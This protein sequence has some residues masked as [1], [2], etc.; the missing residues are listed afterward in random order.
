M[1]LFG[2][3]TRGQGV[4][5]IHLV[6]EEGQQLP[7]AAISVETLDGICLPFR[8]DE[9][10]KPGHFMLTVPSLQTPI[11]V[12]INDGTTEGVDSL[13]IEPKKARFESRKNRLLGNR[14]ARNMRKLSER[15]YGA[16]RSIV[17]SSLIR[18]ETEEKLV[19]RGYIVEMAA[20]PSTASFSLHVLDGQGCEVAL[21]E[22]M[23]LSDSIT[24]SKTC[25]AL[26]ERAVAF[27][28]SV[29]PRLGTCLI[30]AVSDDHPSDF[31]YCYEPVTFRD[32]QAHFVETVCP[33]DQDPRYEQWFYEHRTTRDELAAQRQAHF[34]HEAVFS[35]I[36]PLFNT[37][38][39]FFREMVDSVLAQTY[40]YFELILVNASPERSD[41]AAE[42]TRYAQCDSRIKVVNLQENL[43]ITEN[44]NAGIRIAQ[45]EFL[46][47]FDHDDVLEP[48]ILYWYAEA[49][50]RHPSIDLLYCDE[51]KLLDG[52]LVTPFFKPDWNPDLLRTINYICHMLTVR[53][54]I[55]DD[56]ELP[57][58][59]VD[60]SQDYHMTLRVAEKAR[61][62]Y[63]VRRVLYHWRIHA[64][65]VAGGAEAK[66]ETSEVG[67]R[68]LQ[69]HLD[70]CGIQ[71]VAHLQEGIPN[72]F[73]LEYR[74]PED[75]P[76]VSIVI[77]SKDHSDVLDRC[78]RSIEEYS[79]YRYFEIIVV[80]NNSTEPSTFE[81]YEQIQQDSDRIRVVV[82]DAQGAVNVSQALNVGVS[83]A[84]GEF[85]I[86]L[87]NDTEVITPNWIE[88]MLG[89]CM[90]KEVGAVGAKLLYPDG[91]IQHGGIIFQY[92]YPYNLGACY[93]ARDSRAYFGF[94]Q[95]TQDLSAV[96]A[97]CV[98][99]RKEVYE[100]VEGF[101][102]A[103]PTCYDDV[104]FCLKLLKAG[105][106]VVYEPSVELYHHESLSRK[107]FESIEKDTRALGQM[108]AR[109]PERYTRCDPYISP[110]LEGVQ[111]GLAIQHEAIA[112]PQLPPWS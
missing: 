69:A 51:D 44:T 78:L 6:V 84:R 5:L 40:K 70:R 21:A 103:I 71:A 77:P 75:Q 111:R 66:P 87:N 64:G 7:S 55:V 101:D 54:S 109:Y 48:D 49:L 93:F 88:R 94:L 68:I 3:M 39:D 32:A 14:T 23:F 38:L 1:G 56:L 41:L 81:Y 106:L 37:P 10:E 19:L 96:S 24:T 83:Y 22:P 92:N 46:C 25:P 110:S 36:V 62:I 82:Y 43:G 60:G 95:S 102:P 105:L 42:V 58:S 104:D 90:R 107:S 74:I 63:H 8:I 26:K 34:P 85:V 50:S 89:P 100:Q 9:L 112:I 67:R 31:F 80:E 13:L 33:A 79:T 17:V 35:I 2:E 29:P 47:F 27:S 59:E 57:T 72:T 65:S 18:F 86:L 11:S 45:G 28:V 73:W 30:W 20:Q 16:Q 98:M 12:R 108:M 97:A 76:L 53:K 61:E 99:V 91:V 15:T 4:I 52:H